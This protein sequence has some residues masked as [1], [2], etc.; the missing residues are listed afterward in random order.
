MPDQDPA[1]TGQSPEPSI[2]GGTPPAETPAAGGAAAPGA[3]GAGDA[4]GG[5]WTKHI[6]ED[7]K[8]EKVWEP[9]KGKQL[10]DV[11]K[12]YAHAQKMVGGSVRIPGAD[13]KPEEVAAYH[14]AIGVPDAPDKY[15]VNFVAPD[16]QTVD[17]TQLQGFLGAAHKAGLTPK[18]AQAVLDFYKE[19]FGNAAAAITAK[20]GETMKLLEAEWGGAADV[21]IARAQRALRAY[22]PKGEVLAVFDATGLGNHPAVL[23]LFAKMG[24]DMSED[25]LIEG[26]DAGQ[27]DAAKT[28][29]AEIE[30][31]AK[32]SPYY[33]R[34][35]PDHKKAVEE[36]YRLRQ[37]VY[38][39]VTG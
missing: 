4:A 35:H 27:V 26:A 7:L 9:L 28:K 32:D 1:A 38:N 2:L 3:G 15:E 13:A 30:G 24:A 36:A 14:K 6:P 31:G 5:D 11:L 22:D 20:R 29:L 37:I 18:Q 16:G 19:S 23:K 21:N 33:N 17:Q 10:G 39:S 34:Q 8:N 25:R 12:G